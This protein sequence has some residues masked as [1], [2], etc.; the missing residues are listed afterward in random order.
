MSK[1]NEFVKALR[2]HGAPS[3]V[4]TVEDYWRERKAE[5]L[6]DLEE[7]R[8]LIRQWLKPVV[9][10]NLAVIED[11]DFSTTEPDI[12]HY[13]VR[14]LKIDLLV[15][16]PTTILVRPRGA[17]V[18][19]VIEESGR[20]IVGASGRVDMESASRREILLRF[21]EKKHTAW[22]SFSGGEKRT[23]DEDV[24]FDLLART[25]DVEFP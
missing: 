25:A 16:E 13:M 12:G 9:D 22:R 19:G 7:L 5:W 21:K 8:A 18:A 24:F 4:K 15:G 3:G 2:D 17:R 10:A 11:M 23:L 14:G 20:R 6:T 1:A